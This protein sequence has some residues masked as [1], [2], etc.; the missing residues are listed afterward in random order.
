[1]HGIVK[2]RLDVSSSRNNLVPSTGR[3]VRGHYHRDSIT[4]PLAVSVDKS[5]LEFPT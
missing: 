4:A 2:R 1:M 5:V 3:K